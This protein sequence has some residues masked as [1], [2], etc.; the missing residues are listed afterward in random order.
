MIRFLVLLTAALLAATPAAA[1][2]AP[3]TLF[4]GDDWRLRASAQDARVCLTFVTRGTSTGEPDRE[5]AFKSGFC[6]RVPSRNGLRARARLTGCTDA[7]GGLFALAAPEVARINVSLTSASS[8]R[9]TLR[10]RRRNLRPVLGRQGAAFL[11]RRTLDGR[12]GTLTAYDADGRR[13]SQ[14]AFGPYPV[15]GC[16][17]PPPEPVPSSG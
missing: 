14:A 7:A 12:G 4:D 17:G 2:A 9:V 16:V 1:S 15:P 8:P 11:L 6:A 3:V 5:Q 13:L 10:M